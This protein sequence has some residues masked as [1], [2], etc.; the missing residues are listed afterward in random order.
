MNTKASAR[1]NLLVMALA[2]SIDISVTASHRRR[3]A[4]SGYSPGP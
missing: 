3:H 4:A 1:A 2:E